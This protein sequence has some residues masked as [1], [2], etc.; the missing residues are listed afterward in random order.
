VTVKNVVFFGEV[1]TTEKTQCNLLEKV[2]LGKN[3]KNEVNSI[4]VLNS[5][6]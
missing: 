4:S 2:S 3:L 1:N 6:K 5:S